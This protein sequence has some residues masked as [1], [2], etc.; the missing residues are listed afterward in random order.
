MAIFGIGTSQ[1]ASRSAKTLAAQRLVGGDA[2]KFWGRYFN[3][4]DDMSYQYKP[5]ENAFLRG[6]GIAVLCL[7]RQ[8][9]FVGERVNEEWWLCPLGVNRVILTGCRPLPVC[10]EQ[11]T[12]SSRPDWS[13]SAG[14]GKR[15]F[16]KCP[17]SHLT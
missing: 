11:R 3:G 2:P 1:P 6:L 14:S 13:G 12:S 16:A 15:L 10:P 4:T 17:G 5:S 8:M 7:A 9:K